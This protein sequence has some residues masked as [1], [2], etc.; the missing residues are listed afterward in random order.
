MKKLL[1]MTV[2][3]LGSIG[4]L[5]AEMRYNPINNLIYSHPE[6]PDINQADYRL[7]LASCIAIEA[8]MRAMNSGM[9]PNPKIIIDQCTAYLNSV[10]TPTALRVIADLNKNTIHYYA[11][12]TFMKNIF[13]IPNDVYKAQIRNEIENTIKERFGFKDFRLPN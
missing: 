9:L 3:I 8:N 13:S 4:H 11:N 6:T 1:L 5:L 10:G 12:G 7:L 2:L